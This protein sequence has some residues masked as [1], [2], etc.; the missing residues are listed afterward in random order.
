VTVTNGAGIAAVHIAEFCIARLLAIWK[1]FDDLADLQAR[2]EWTP[3]YGRS[4]SGSTVGVVGLGAIGRAV[5]ERA[6]AMGA[7]VIGVRRNAQLGGFAFVE[8]IY[9][10]EQL[11]EMLGQCDAVVLSAPSTATTADLFDAAA[12]AAMKPG[13]VFCNVA[14]GALVDEVALLDALHSGHLG[15][16]AL[17]VTKQEPIPSDSPL[18]HVPRLQLSPHSAGALEGYIDNLFDLFADNLSRYLRREPLRNL[19]DLQ[20][21]Y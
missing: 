5:A 19:V 15:A 16:A 2:R 3:T 12:F 21:G 20:A 14:R 8:A 7:R 4:F 17:D 10:P 6:H 13:A 18:W 9:A 11:H 1:R